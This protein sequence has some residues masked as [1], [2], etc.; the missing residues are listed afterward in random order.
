MAGRLCPKGLG[1]ET[2][3][4]VYEQEAVG[5][6]AGWMSRILYEIRKHSNRKNTDA[7]LS[8]WY[9]PP[10]ALAD[11]FSTLLFRFALIIFCKE[12][13]KNAVWR[14]IYAFCTK[15]IFFSC[16]FFQV[17]AMSVWVCVV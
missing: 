5:D 12:G 14:K 2:D 7:K 3:L 17:W 6:L 11:P 4:S 8:D 16:F 9:S 1:E 10:G 13:A 15:R